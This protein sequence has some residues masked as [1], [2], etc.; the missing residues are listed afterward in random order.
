MTPTF[1]EK[2]L[3]FNIK[4]VYDYLAKKGVAHLT[5]QKGF[6]AILAIGM[7][8]GLVAIPQLATWELRFYCVAVMSFA[9]GCTGC[10]YSG[11]VANTQSIAPNYSGTVYGLR[12]FAAQ[13]TGFMMPAVISAFTR[14][15]GCEG[16]ATRWGYAF[17]IFAGLCF[18]G[19]LV[20]LLFATAEEQP[21][22][23]ND[24]S[25]SKVLKTPSS[26]RSSSGEGCHDPK[27]EP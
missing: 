16:D 24:Y 13:I 3:H 27:R 12:N 21:F 14:C 2:V 8:A 22:N 15:E 7:T 1:M 17:W 19:M 25:G 6:V 26:V 23:D 5:L 10:D 18:F 9:F 20:F 4:D 11:G